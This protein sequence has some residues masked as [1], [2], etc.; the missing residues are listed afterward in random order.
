MGEAHSLKIPPSDLN[1]SA[2]QSTDQ[3]STK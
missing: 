1:L 2:E 3:S